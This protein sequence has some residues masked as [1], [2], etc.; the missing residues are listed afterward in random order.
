MRRKLP[1]SPKPSAQLP[2]KQLTSPLLPLFASPS[3]PRPASTSSSATRA[4]DGGPSPDTYWA[5]PDRTDWDFDN[6]IYCDSTGCSYD[7]KKNPRIAKVAVTVVEFDDCSYEEYNDTVFLCRQCNMKCLRKV[8]GS[9]IKSKMPI[10]R[11]L[12][13]RESE[14]QSDSFAASALNLLLPPPTAADFPELPR[15]TPAP[16]VTTPKMTKAEKAMAK[17]ID[18]LLLSSVKGE[19][20]LVPAPADRASIPVK[21]TAVPT[22]AA[23]PLVPARVPG[24]LP[25]T[26]T[27][28]NDIP[29]LSPQPSGASTPIMAMAALHAEHAVSC[30]HDT[31]S[32]GVCRVG[33]TC[34][35]CHLMYTAPAAKRMRCTKC[36]HWA[37]DLD[38]SVG[39][40]E[41]GTPW[42]PL[43]II[44]SS[45]TGTP[46]QHATRV[47]GGASSSNA[48]EASSVGKSQDDSTVKIRIS[49]PTQESL[50]E[51]D[52]FSRPPSADPARERGKP[53]KRRQPKSGRNSRESSR[54]ASVAS[55]RLSTTETV[56]PKLDQ[57]VPPLAHEYNWTSPPADPRTLP[58][59]VYEAHQEK[60][61]HVDDEDVTHFLKRGDVDINDLSNQLDILL[62]GN[63]SWK[64]VYHA[65]TDLFQFDS[66]AG[67][68]NDFICLLIGLARSW[69]DDAE[70]NPAGIVKTLINDASALVKTEDELH[71]AQTAL[72]RIRNERNQAMTDIK[73]LGETVDRLR[74][75]R[76]TLKAAM[77]DIVNSGGVAPTPAQFEQLQQEAA[78]LKDEKAGLT[79]IIEHDKAA[80]RT[81][82][83][84]NTAMTLQ[85]S[86]M[87]EDF[88]DKN[89]IIEECQTTMS[90]MLKKQGEMEILSM[91]AKHELES[92]KSVIATMKEQHEAERKVYESHIQRLKARGPD[93]TESALAV[94]TGDD[95][96]R[97]ELALA[98]E[99]V[100]FLEKAYKEKSDAL[101][102]AN[103]AAKK[104]KDQ[105]TTPKA[106]DKSQNSLKWGFEPPDDLPHSQPYWDYRNAYSDHIAAV[107]AATVSAILHIPLSSAISSAITTVTK[108]GPPPELAQKTKGKRSS[109][110][111]RPTSPAPR[112]VPPLP[113]SPS[114]PV[115]PKP[116]PPPVLTHAKLTMAQIVAGAGSFSGGSE[117]SA[118][119]AAKEKK[120]TWH[121]KETSKQIVTKPG[122]RSTRTT[123]LHLRIPRCDAT[124]T[125]Y[126]SSGSRLVNE[127]IAMLNKSANADEIQAYKANPIVTAKWSARSNLLLK[128][129]QPMGEMLK[130]AVERSIRKNIPEGQMD[131][132]SDV[133]VLNRPPTTSLKFMAVPRYNED[134]SPTDSADL[135]SD[136][137]AN[138]AWA[139][140]TFFS[141][142]KFL[143][144]NRNAASGIVV[145]TIVDDEQGNVGK[146]LMRTMVS[147][148]G[149]NRPCL[150]WV[151][152][153]VQPF[154]G[155]CMM[156]GHD[157][158][159]CTSNILR[160]SKCGEGHDYKN[161]EKFCETCK[162]GA[163]HICVPKCFNCLGNHFSTSKDCEF[164]K[165]R[166]DREWQVDT[167][168]RNHPSSNTIRKRVENRARNEAAAAAG[169]NETPDWIR[170]R[171]AGDYDAK[172]EDDTGFTKV[173]RKGKKVTFPFEEPSARIDNVDDGWDNGKDKPASGSI[174]PIEYI[175]KVIASH[176]P[177]HMVDKPTKERAQYVED[178]VS[179]MRQRLEEF[180]AMSNRTRGSKKAD[181]PE[182][183]SSPV[184]IDLVTP[185]VQQAGSDLVTPE[186]QAR[187]PEVPSL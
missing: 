150:R 155:Q 47:R 43:I 134:G 25:I 161:H 108:A 13:Q 111:S 118:V 37:C 186:N 88:D 177:S 141:D 115:I 17:K 162:K 178:E 86:L 185:E 87:N 22:Q 116:S 96:L 2:A 12:A 143:S 23:I 48:S 27:M 58:G 51:I 69:D 81:A 80:L 84:E 10:E 24:I 159:N 9:K 67:T 78:L 56:L 92:A 31:G 129:S 145:L 38:Q 187:S 42:V 107:V 181:K 138:Q 120:V 133:E 119:N 50:D 146:K 113:T 158:F 76:N 11:F 3:A 147:F 5:Q 16:K 29:E 98:K 157:G 72:S 170:R 85:I 26:G 55:D 168:K 70:C 184:V 137:K 90:D 53:K 103:S 172:P 130:V 18:T 179:R 64:T 15:A 164:Y 62:S 28:R 36:L 68:R 160:C 19:H 49:A 75:D 127:V 114:P 153:P 46:A 132:D 144:N 169:A 4:A 165:R 183:A 140:V 99:C 163:G 102:A 131:E 112:R 7:A 152:L 65:I 128:C 142:P 33:I 63:S 104:P 71:A 30:S 124:K 44:E 154:C 74:K 156:W 59:Y 89:A 117:A 8:N 45:H 93:A 97:K 175:D 35:K 91:A 83:D 57:E 109:S 95:Q 106:G 125:L 173:N 167:F 14:D 66:I 105:Q 40:C 94:T 171:M 6:N 60:T 121:M 166:T 1:S 182:R 110:T 122:A 20:V 149:A 39:C 176:A 34:C 73:K 123:E 82:E 52:A 79:K 101:K 32:C 174:S 135:Y 151:D 41:C 136:I 148:S 77:E 54:P 61:L 139:D 21:T 126:K 180:K 100:A